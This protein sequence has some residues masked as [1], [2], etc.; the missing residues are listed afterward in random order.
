[1]GSRNAPA[2][3]ALQSPLLRLGSPEIQ[4]VVFGRLEGFFVLYLKKKIWQSLFYTC[5][6]DFGVLWRRKMNFFLSPLAC[7]ITKIGF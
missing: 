4:F 6:A 5:L 1:M 2:I 7:V 3:W